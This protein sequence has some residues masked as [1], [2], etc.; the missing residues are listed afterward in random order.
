M[1]KSNIK[2]ENYTKEGRSQEAEVESPTQ[3]TRVNRE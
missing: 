3:N 1:Q 2:K